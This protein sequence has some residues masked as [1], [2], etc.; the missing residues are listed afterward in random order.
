[1]HF[2]YEPIES[3]DGTTLNQGD[4]LRRTEDMDELLR[5]IHPHYYGQSEYRFLIVLTQS[6]DLERRES[7][8]KAR[9]LTLA[10]VRPLTTV[11]EREVEELRRSQVETKAHIADLSRRPTVEQFVQRLL[12]NNESSYFYLHQEIEAGLDTPHCAFLRLSIAVRSSDHYEKCLAAKVLQLKAEF[13]A[14][15]GWLVGNMYSRVGTPDWVPSAEDSAAFRRHVADLVDST[16][17]WVDKKVLPKLVKALEDLGQ[18]ITPELVNATIAELKPVPRR[19]V[20]LKR[21]RE[22]LP[23][24][25]LDPTKVEKAI[26]Q[27]KSDPAFSQSLKD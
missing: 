17:I 5:S 8:C 9:Y 11:L 18:T 27:I 3:T 14:K 25:G 7:R 1:M 24:V 19:D 20:A 26:A 21:L 13:Q 10:A 12:N 23:Q 4:V 2:T 15:L 16:T 6:C 22:L